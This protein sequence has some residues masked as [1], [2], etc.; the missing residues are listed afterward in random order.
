M[1]WQEATQMTGYAFR[2]LTNGTTSVKHRSG[3]QW[4]VSYDRDDNIYVTEVK[5]QHQ[6]FADKS[7]GWEELPLESELFE[8]MQE[9]VSFTVPVNKEIKEATGL[10]ATLLKV[11]QLKVR[12]GTLGG[13]IENTDVTEEG[14]DQLVDELIDCTNQLRLLL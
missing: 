2:D 12:I 13:D 1:N 3:Q 14:F 7:Q 11:R 8:N 6:A 5:K 9:R 10:R 4:S